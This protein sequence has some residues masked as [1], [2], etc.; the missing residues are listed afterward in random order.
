MEAIPRP[1]KTGNPFGAGIRR[2]WAPPSPDDD[3]SVG[4]EVAQ[5]VALSKRTL[6]VQEESANATARALATAKQTEQLGMENLVKLNAQG[7]QLDSIH[8]KTEETGHKIKIAE[9]KTS[10]LDKLSDS[11]L[12]PIFGGEKQIN[13]KDSQPFEWK[14]PQGVDGKPLWGRRISSLPEEFPGA[15]AKG[16]EPKSTV[17][18]GGMLGDW[19]D[20]EDKTQSE[21]H[22]QVIEENMGQISGIVKGIKY[23]AQ[24]MG[25]EIERQNHVIS[26]TEGNVMEQTDRIQGV[27]RRLDKIS[28]K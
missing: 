17:K 19:A 4:D 20:E 10:Y 3:S 21:V 7:E 27:N 15:I 25:Q 5:L 13:Q 6:E 11:F 16:A 1:T 23:Q 28:R 26:R 2:S 24:A 18:P 8:V 22:E 12:R 9:A 14:A